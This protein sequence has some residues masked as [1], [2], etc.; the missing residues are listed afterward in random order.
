MSFLKRI[1]F[2]VLAGILFVS[3]FVACE[4]ELITIGD[5]LIGGEL[6][7]TDT[8][9]YPVF[10]YNK[11]VKAVQANKLSVYQL[12]VFND[13]VFG[14]TEAQITSQI[15]LSKVNPTFG[16]FSKEVEDESGTDDKATTIEENEQVEKVTLFIPYLTRSSTQRDRDNDGVDD[17]FDS[18]PDNAE[19]DSD[20]DGVSNIQ[21]KAN[22]TDPLVKNVEGDTS[23]KNS[24]AKK[25][26]L[27]SIYG[28]S[29]IVEGISSFNLKVKRL[30]FFL[31]DLDP[32]A[33]FE[34][35]QMYFSHQ[36]FAPDFVS[37]VLYNGAVTINSLETI[38][39]KED[40]PETTD[41]DESLEVASR[42]AP[43]ISVELDKT[44]FQEIL[45][46][47]GT[48]DILSQDNF[49]HFFRGIHL[50]V[51]DDVLILLDLVKAKVI[52]DYTYR[53]IDTSDDDKEIEAKG[54]YVFNL[55]SRVASGTVGNAVNTL[56]SEEYPVAVKDELETIGDV[57][58]IYLKGGAGTYAEIKLFDTGNGREII[59]QIKSNKWIINEANLVFNIDQDALG[60]DAIEPGRLYLYNSET[61]EPIF[62][63]FEGVDDKS[64]YGSFL[65][66]DGRIVKSNEGKGTKYKIRITEY[67]NGLIADSDKENV[68]LRLTLTSDIRVPVVFTALL[69][70]GEVKLPV[71]SGIN[72]LGTV[73][74]GGKEISGKEDKKLKL[75]I[76]YT[77]AN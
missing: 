43:G 48:A 53:K 61:N 1:T 74:F 51:S 26:Q 36:R 12:G 67:I 25:Y 39:K 75:E 57:S 8:K 38:I 77:T 76:F 37:D 20:G 68:T 33:N 31:R 24:F 56:I 44:L 58:R 9:E 40:D 70:D 11:K 27:D 45:D 14:K 23:P 28:N 15:Q 71:M 17:M 34:E 52:M 63:K 69:E 13:A 7:T 62:G 72:P 50:S 55:L 59:D 46:K 22:G 18:E 41:V 5:G 47:E 49:K 32:N 6:F 30:T 16:L 3:V 35:S 73:L 10:A 60:S 66:Y 29:D 42:I 65:N 19:N 54:S 64:E 2:P 4:E 21:E